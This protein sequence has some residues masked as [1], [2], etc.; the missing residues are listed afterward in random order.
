MPEKKD[1]EL[2]PKIEELQE[3]LSKD[4]KSRLFLQLAEEYRKSGMPEEAIEVCKEGLKHH[5]TYIA[6]KVTLGKAYLD[7]KKIDDAQHIFEDVIEQSSDNLVANRNLADIYYMKGF[8]D[9]SL[10][11]Y[12]IINMYNANDQLV[13]DRIKELQEQ[14]AE[15]EP[16]GMEEDKAAEGVAEKAEVEEEVPAGE[17]Q[18]EEGAAEEKE[19]KAEEIIPEEETQPEEL[20][21][22][23]EEEIGQITPIEITTMDEKEELPTEEET[24][25]TEG[26]IIQEVDTSE[27]EGYG[28]EEIPAVKIDLPEAEEEEN[29]KLNKKQ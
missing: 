24:K 20:I 26:L 13:A 16:I 21:E 2:S 4:P 8:T 3:K 10:K 28:I 23:S 25:E 19:E 7:L 6:A 1:F 18:A 9:E 17:E 29:Y 27:E 14:L 5:P 22:V 15:P 11:H 12:K